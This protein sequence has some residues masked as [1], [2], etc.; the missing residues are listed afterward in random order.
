MGIKYL[1]IL[2][3]LTFFVHTNGFLFWPRRPNC[4]AVSC[5]WGS[6]NSWGSCRYNVGTCG[7][8]TRQRNRGIARHASC[9]GSGCHGPSVQTTSCSKCCPKNCMWNSWQNWDECSKSCGGGSQ[10]RRRSIKSFQ[11]CGG[12]CPGSSSD[13][14]ECNKYICPQNDDDCMWGFGV[15]GAPV[16]RAVVEEFSQKEDTS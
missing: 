4:R 5:I 6:W 15:L 16:L 9:R 3:C 12:T 1:T 11:Q 7:T 10:I 13:S 8:G 14:K 2:I